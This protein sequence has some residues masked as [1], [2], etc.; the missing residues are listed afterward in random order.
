MKAYFGVD[1][2]DASRSGLD[3]YNADAG[4]KDVGLNAVLSYLITP[5][6]DVTGI[7]AYRRLVGDAEDSPVTKEGS[8]NQWYGGLMFNYHF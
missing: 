1:S 4:I 8:A 6:W 2:A 5:S 3:R 7:A